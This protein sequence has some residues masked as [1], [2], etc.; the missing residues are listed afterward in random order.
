MSPPARLLEI[1]PEWLADFLEGKALLRVTRTCRAACSGRHLEQ[2]AAARR[3]LEG[4]A[5]FLQRTPVNLPFFTAS[6]RGKVRVQACWDFAEM[7][8][9]KFFVPSFMT[10]HFGTGLRFG[11]KD[12]IVGR[13]SAYLRGL[14][15]A[16]A[17]RELNCFLP[18]NARPEFDHF[19]SLLERNSARY[20]CSYM[21][22]RE[23]CPSDCPCRAMDDSDIE[24]DLDYNPVEP[25]LVIAFRYDAFNVAICARR[26]RLR[27]SS[28]A[29]QI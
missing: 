16:Q 22:H 15:P 8:P 2:A 27:A 3:A 29:R 19:M 10:G 1:L 17:M 5:R 9:G 14:S 4:L 24:M 23:D 20:F 28:L 11:L 25:G 12:W 18:D 26:D 13:A 6:D 21:A 7:C